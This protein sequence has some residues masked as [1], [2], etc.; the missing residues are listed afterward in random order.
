LVADCEKRAGAGSDELSR[1]PKGYTETPIPK[2]FVVV[3]G[4]AVCDPKDLADLID[5][6]G[7]QLEI[8][9]TAKEGDNERDD[10]RTYALMVF[11]FSCLPLAWY[12]VLDRI[13]ELSAAIAGR[14][15]NS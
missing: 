8:A 1:L 12:L 2:G 3:P 9:D 15:R 6:S 5:L 7:Y 11:L 10:A 14:D 4:P 13:R